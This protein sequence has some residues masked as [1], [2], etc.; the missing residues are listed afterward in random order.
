MRR[1]RTQSGHLQ[2]LRHL[3]DRPRHRRVVRAVTL[4]RLALSSRLGRG[5][6]GRRGGGKGG[7]GGKGSGGRRRGLKEAAREGCA[8][9]EGGGRR[10]AFH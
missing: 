5:G 10:R 4:F 2:R 7:G 6:S 1:R 8:L 3:R 9:L